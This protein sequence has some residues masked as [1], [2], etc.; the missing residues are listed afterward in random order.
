MDP[1]ITPE[2]Y[3]EAVN[4][5]EREKWMEAMK[6][7]FE[8]LKENGTYTLYSMFEGD[9][10]IDAKWVYKI[11]L[12]SQN[13]IV[14]FKCRYVARGF[15]QQAGQNYDETFAPVVR[16][17]NIRTL[18]SIVAAEGWDV[19]HSDVV[20]AF[21]NPAVDFDNIIMRP[22]KGFE[23]YDSDGKPYMWKLNKGLYGIKQAA[24]L[25]NQELSAWFVEHGYEVL[26]SD[27]SIF[28]RTDENGDTI[29]I[30]T[31]VDDL[32]GTGNNTETVKKELEKIGARFKMKHMG[33]VKWYQNMV[34]E[35]NPEKYTVQMHQSPF[36]Q[37]AVDTF[38]LTDAH[39]TKT[40]LPA[41]ADLEKMTH[42][43]VNLRK[44]VGKLQWVSGNTRPDITDSVGKLSRV[45]HE[46]SHEHESMAKHIWKY[47]KGTSDYGIKYS[48][49]ACPHKRNVLEGWT[50]AALGD[51]KGRSTG[52]GLL[53]MNEG[54]TQWASKV[55]DTVALSSVESEIIALAAV[56]Q[57]VLYTRGLL[58]ELG[59]PQT[60]PT[61]VYVD[62]K[63]AYAYGNNAGG[64]T[65]KR[66]L[67]HLDMRYYFIKDN[68]EKKIIRVVDVRSAEQLAD[69]MTKTL[70]PPA[71]KAA[72]ARLIH[73]CG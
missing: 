45:M 28:R 65:G 46:A 31:Y 9:P 48:R 50:D 39:P 27:R 11:K 36:I 41:G 61:P 1:P 67:R 38:G 73:K 5:P 66:N 17:Q 8:S 64:Y 72:A 70:K 7:E 20:T 62:N 55:Q 42:G 23:E 32:I 44:S 14:R 40:P 54:P 26:K 25:W 35:V 10:L 15:K 51:W 24:F 2:T 59:F 71:H 47:L 68:V 29:I 21:L 6:E 22:P 13:E 57:E 56:L 58:E 49:P 34:I 16:L 52:G 33:R 60:E 18:L 53:F 3:T 63:G 69:I 43:D 37:Q 19:L 12:G 30:T 4:S